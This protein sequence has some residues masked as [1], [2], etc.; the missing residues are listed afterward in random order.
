MNCNYTNTASS[1]G[2][3]QGTR[4]KHVYGNVLR[5]AIPL[6]QRVRTMVDG[7][8]TE[9][10]AP[11]YPS[12][13]HPVL[14][15]L[16]KGGG[17]V[18]T[19]T[20]TMNDNVALVEDDGK[21]TMG[22]YQVEV[23]CYDTNDK[24]CRYMVRAI[25]EIVDATIDAG[26]QAGIE[27]NAETYTLDGTIYYY[28]KGDRG[29]S[30]TNVQQIVESTENGGVN[31]IRVTLDDGNTFDFNVRNANITPDQDA[32]MRRVVN[33]EGV[34]TV[35]SDFHFS[36]PDHTFA[37]LVEIIDAG[38]LI[39]LTFLYEDM[40][41]MDCIS[42][43]SM[44][45][46]YAFETI[47]STFHEYGGN[48][49]LYF[50]SAREGDN[51]SIAL[52]F[53]LL[54]SENYYTRRQTNEAITNA[55]T[56]LEQNKLGYSF[57]AL[58]APSSADTNRLYFVVDDNT[59]DVSTYISDGHEWHR[60]G[61]FKPATGIPATDLEA[62]IQAT[63]AHAD[64]TYTKAE[65]DAAIQ[66]ARL[67]VF[68]Y[69]GEL[70]TASA[71]TLGKIYLVP[72]GS[73][74][75]RNYCDEYITV[76]RDGYKWE[77]IGSTEVNLDNYATLDYVAS[78]TKMLKLR[79]TNP[80]EWESGHEAIAK[81]MF[82]GVYKG[83]SSS[84]TSDT[85]TDAILPIYTQQNG[86]IYHFVRARYI[87][88]ESH[89]IQGVTSIFHC[90]QG[91]ASKTM[92]ITTTRTGNITSLTIESDATVEDKYIELSGYYTLQKH[93]DGNVS[94]YDY[95]DAEVDF[96]TALGD[97]Q[98]HKSFVHTDENLDPMNERASDSEHILLYTYQKAEYYYLQSGGQQ[99]YHFLINISDGGAMIRRL[100]LLETNTESE[101]TL[102]FDDL[103]E[104]NLAALNDNGKID[105]YL[106]DDETR[107]ALEKARNIKYVDFDAVD[108]LGSTISTAIREK[109]IAFKDNVFD[110]NDI[111]FIHYDSNNTSTSIPLTIVSATAQNFVFSFFADGKFVRV[112]GDSSNI[113]TKN[114]KD[115]TT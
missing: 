83:L 79:T 62:A 111:W 105:P 2:D 73:S 101:H 91:D 97:L 27:F 1:S 41:A 69:V 15:T 99:I 12:P 33:W 75:A 36:I 85:D 78:K 10:E 103:E 48:F 115:I 40:P 29:I 42:K 59:T 51:G 8:E 86:Y 21:T 11:F 113:F 72:N 5:L 82:A 32:A 92:T 87:T 52:S 7:E 100:T 47:D 89:I 16:N 90:D 23:K 22:V 20:A 94:F 6:T 80:I 30:V 110:A 4:I 54:D 26:I 43:R 63:L 55:T 112:V 98:W 13:N 109:L 84:S 74:A 18:H 57:S 39:H 58:P 34:M 44:G 77:K 106:F 95:N 108:L 104:I 24:P 64:D 67:L 56:P 3:T 17:L 45:Y 50:L 68:V 65:V 71:N 49:G 46:G 66:A 93:N 76:Q 28:A 96:N 114:I 81:A 14:V 19:F 9:T 25:V 53:S 31:V 35:D 60:I 88:N 107:A 70:P 61:Y 37:E 102:V 38:N